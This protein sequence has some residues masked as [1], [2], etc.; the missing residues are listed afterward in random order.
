MEVLTCFSW[1]CRWVESLPPGFAKDAGTYWLTQGLH[2]N[3]RLEMPRK[4][5]AMM[6]RMHP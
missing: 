6:T 5:E 4:I 3:L 2:Y 1:W